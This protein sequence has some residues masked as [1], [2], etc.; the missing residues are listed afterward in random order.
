MDDILIFGNSKQEHDTRLHNVL[1][2]LQATG[3][4]GHV[5]DKEGIS[6]DPSKTNAIV[7]MCRPRT[8]TDPGDF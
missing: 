1:Q 6:A 7:S 8:P 3:V 5:M 2:K 4:L